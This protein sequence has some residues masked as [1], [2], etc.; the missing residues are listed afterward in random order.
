M[1]HALRTLLLL[2]A[3]ALLTSGPVRADAVSDAVD[4]LAAGDNR[5]ALMLLKG[6]AR[7]GN[8]EAMYLLGGMYSSGT[9]VKADGEEAVRW[10]SQAAEQ[11]HYEAANTLMKMYLSG[12]GVPVDEQEA[13]KWYNLAAQI[14]ETNKKSSGDCN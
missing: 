8:I 7:E 11:G 6:P 3:V 14:A 10:L 13:Q 12:L 1:P 2:T 4:A 5:R 9:G